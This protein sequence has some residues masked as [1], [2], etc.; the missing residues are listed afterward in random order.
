MALRIS[1]QNSCT[2][3]L[4]MH[5]F[6]SNSLCYCMGVNTRTTRAILIVMELDLSGTFGQIIWLA[7]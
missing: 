3:K 7:N 1:H 4:I 5:A 6:T 2:L